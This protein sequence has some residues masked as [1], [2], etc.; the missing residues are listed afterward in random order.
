MVVLTKLCGLN[1]SDD[2]TQVTFNGPDA[3]FTFDKDLTNFPDW[4]VDLFVDIEALIKSKVETKLEGAFV[5]GHVAHGAGVGARDAG[6]ALRATASRR[7]VDRRCEVHEGQLRQR[8][9]RRSIRPGRRP[10]AADHLP[11]PFT[12]NVGATL[13]Q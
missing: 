8:Q 7:D 13:S 4:F 1:P 6:E 3:T 11:P 9:P 5:Q 10:A 12:V 2:G